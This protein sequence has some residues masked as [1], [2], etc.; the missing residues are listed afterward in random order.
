MVDTYF[1]NIY[2]ALYSFENHLWLTYNISIKYNVCTYIIKFINN[3][4]NVCHWQCWQPLWS[5]HIH[6]LCTMYISYYYDLWVMMTISIFNMYIYIILLTCGYENS[7]LMGT[8]LPTLFVHCNWYKLNT[9]PRINVLLLMIIDYSGLYYCSIMD[10]EN[11]VYHRNC[12]CQT[13][14][15]RYQFFFHQI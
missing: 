15:K 3:K 9:N 1:C 5:L 6:I 7:L 8:Y 2:L 13:W 4:K 12:L 11:S 10:D 14:I